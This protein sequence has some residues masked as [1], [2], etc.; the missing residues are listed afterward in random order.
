[1]SVNVIDVV[2]K[3]ENCIN[4][5]RSWVV[6]SASGLECAYPCRLVRIIFGRRPVKAN[7][8]C[9]HFSAIGAQKTR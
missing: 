5:K 2:S 8:W 7:G 4:C 3:S 9:K 1:M 6:N